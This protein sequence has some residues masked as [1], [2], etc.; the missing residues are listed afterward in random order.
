MT[1]EHA[2]LV[3]WMSATTADATTTVM[4]TNA[5]AREANPI[6]STPGTIVFEKA[7]IGAAELYFVHRMEKD[8]PKLVRWIAAGAT[9]G[10]SIAAAHNLSVYAQQRQPRR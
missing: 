6:Y 10:Y 2:L 9:I 5:G 1:I 4:A 7:A 8:H 3:A